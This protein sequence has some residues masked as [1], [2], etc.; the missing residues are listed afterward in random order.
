[1]VYSKNELLFDFGRTL[2]QIWKSCQRWE[3]KTCYYCSSY[4]FAFKESEK[5]NLDIEFPN[6]IWRIYLDTNNVISKLKIV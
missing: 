6:D 4:F 3:K 5:Q 2:N 1:M